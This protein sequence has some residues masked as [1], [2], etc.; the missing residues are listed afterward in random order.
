[1]SELRCQELG[2][3]VCRKP[4]NAGRWVNIAEGIREANVLECMK[5]AECIAG[6]NSSALAIGECS[7][8]KNVTG[9]SSW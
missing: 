1:M 8:S 3:W 5:E 2:E 7:S 4:Q 9:A 6:G